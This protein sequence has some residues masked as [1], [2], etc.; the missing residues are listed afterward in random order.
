MVDRKLSDLTEQLKNK[1]SAKRRVAAKNL[2]KLKDSKAGAAL[3]AALIAEVSDKRT[4]ETQYQMIMALGQS[5]YSES[6][7]VL[8]D[9]SN[10]KF[11]SS[12]IYIALGD[13]ITTLEVAMD[14]PNL[15]LERWIWGDLSDLVQGGLRS[16]AM[17]RSVPDNRLI[18]HI[19]THVT[20]SDGHMSNFWAVA[21]SPGW[22]SVLSKPF[23]EAVIENG[24]YES[25][26]V[27]KAAKASL[28]GQYLKW[29]PL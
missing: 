28:R 5:G 29:S 1:S 7:G 23:L 9:L 3:L 10:K 12:M 8:I 14:H 20:K 4:W 6:L 11:E 24:E 18:E 16:L 27:L 2:R 25:E 15:S 26:D 21:A 22:P 17:N 19:I 13:A